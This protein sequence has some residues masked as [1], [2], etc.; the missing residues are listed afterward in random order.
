MIWF[1]S[2]AAPYQQ[3]AIGGT[4]TDDIGDPLPGVTVLVMGTSLGTVTDLDGNFLLENVPA[5]ATLQFSFIGMKTVEVAI[6]SGNVVNITMEQE[7]I[8]LD[9]VVAIGYGRQ[10]RRDITGAISSVRSDDFNKGI[11]NRPNN[12]CREKYLA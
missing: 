9:E 2:I 5:S 1:Q 4:V 3:R 8:G 6:G 11:I 10:Q 12:F 7:T